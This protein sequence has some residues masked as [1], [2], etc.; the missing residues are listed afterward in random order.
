ME[1]IV[2]KF[3]DQFGCG[4]VIALPNAHGSYTNAQVPPWWWQEITAAEIADLKRAAEE[5]VVE[6][7]AKRQR[8]DAPASL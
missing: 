3:V 7:G 2:A 5:P 4:W 8:P 1:A 6:Q